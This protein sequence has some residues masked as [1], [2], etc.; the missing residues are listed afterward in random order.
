MFLV[1]LGGVA[2]KQKSESSTAEIAE[3]LDGL[4]RLMDRTKVMYEQYFMGIQKL[5]PNQLHRDIERK[6]REL[7]RN[8]LRN[9]G[10]RY[11]MTNL[12]QRFGS[13][14]SY[15]KRTLRKIENG[16]YVRDV[17]RAARRAAQSDEDI[18]EEIL[19][20]M[21]K[22][23]RERILRDRKRAAD[24]QARR[25][26]GTPKTEKQAADSTPGNVHKI[27]EQDLDGLDFDAMFD[28]I[29]NQSAQGT[30][31]STPAPASVKKTASVAKSPSRIPPAVKAK[32]PPIPKQTATKK[33][34][35]K[36]PAVPQKVSLPPGMSEKQSKE[37]YKQYSSARN[38]VGK[39]SQS[40]EKLMSSLSKQAPQIIKKH[41]AAGVD[42]KVEVKD[43]K[44]V[45]K[46][47]PTK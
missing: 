42:F 8:K 2:K 3:M 15:W 21:P 1:E 18:P 44:V 36:V 41:K 25:E 14:N 34:P 22:R 12:S 10:Q 11:R 33:V 16:T 24:I 19:N 26:E 37:L 20:A 32:A 30:S 28:A 38:Q 35:P 31:P 6:I 13:Y 47:K 4:E 5:P 29:T 27:E 46:A 45:V 7:T 39:K 23:M 43:N 9:T 40:Y 17:A